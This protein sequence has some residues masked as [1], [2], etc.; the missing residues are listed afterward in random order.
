LDGISYLVET[1]VENPLERVAAEDAVGDQCVD[2]GRAFALE[3][4][5]GA[6]DGVGGIGEIVHEDA[7]LARDGADEE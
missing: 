7:C 6:R 5:R 1:T 3:Q 2:F 4:F